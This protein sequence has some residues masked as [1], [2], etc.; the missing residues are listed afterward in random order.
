M[1]VEDPSKLCWFS[2]NFHSFSKTGMRNDKTRASAPSAIEIN[3]ENRFFIEVQRNYIWP[4]L[5]YID[6]FLIS[7]ND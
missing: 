2:D 3:A 5:L 1:K 7:Q 6:I 4:K